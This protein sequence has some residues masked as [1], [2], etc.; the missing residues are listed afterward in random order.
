MPTSM[1]RAAAAGSGFAVA[2]KPHKTSVSKAIESFLDIERFPPEAR[3]HAPESLFE[4][5]LGLPAQQL[6]G[7]RD[8]GLADLR[9][10]YGQRFEHDLAIRRSDLD[11]CLRELQKR[12]L[13]WISEVDGQVLTAVRE[14]VYAADQIIYVTEAPSLGAV[15]EHGERLVLERLADEGRNRAPVV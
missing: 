1:P 4:L 14:Q 5:D 8:I 11:N 6:P 2:A 9:I 15:A 7:S 3:Q 10:I 13:L 12:K